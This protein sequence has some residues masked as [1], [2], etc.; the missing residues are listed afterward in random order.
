[1]PWVLFS[2]V[3]KGCAKLQGMY[4]A[5]DAAPWDAAGEAS[6]AAA[7]AQQTRGGAA[8]TQQNMGYPG[9]KDGMP[10]TDQAARARQPSRAAGRSRG[11]AEPREGSRPGSSSMIG[12]AHEGQQGRRATAGQHGRGPT[13]SPRGRGRG[14]SPQLPKKRRAPDSWQHRRAEPPTGHHAVPKHKAAP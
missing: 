1:M 4:C 12:G 3:M 13:R 6:K 9:V 5:A 8:D 14:R 2:R 10:S 11:Q 7:S